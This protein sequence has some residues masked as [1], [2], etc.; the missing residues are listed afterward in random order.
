[1]FFSF[2]IILFCLVPC[3]RLSWLYSSAFRRMHVNILHRI[4]SYRPCAI[5]A[6][7]QQVTSFDQIDIWS[8]G[9]R[10]ASG[11]QVLESKRRQS[12]SIGVSA[13]TYAT[14]TARYVRLRQSRKRVFQQKSGY[15]PARGTAETDQTGSGR[16][17]DIP[18]LGSAL[19]FNQSVFV[20]FILSPRNASRSI[21]MESSEGATLRA[22]LRQMLQ[23]INAN[24][25]FFCWECYP[26]RS[27]RT[28]RLCHCR[29][30]PVYA[31]VREAPFIAFR[32]SRRRREMFW[33]RA[34]VCVCVSVPRRMPMHT[35]VGSRM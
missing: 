28:H 23:S 26:I 32:V 31:S 27:N 15:Q 11:P 8:F 22:H 7:A 34:S 18:C 13:D 19:L 16:N 2:F 10:R 35:T 20:L 33:S 14:A 1:L 30:S 5:D 9:M 29:H 4:V 17:G 25:L 12:K 21:E 3:G 24:M 6:A